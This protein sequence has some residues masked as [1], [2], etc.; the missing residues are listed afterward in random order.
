MITNAAIRRR[1]KHKTRIKFLKIKNLTIEPQALTKGAYW[2]E[3]GSEPVRIGDVTHIFFPAAD[4]R[5]GVRRV[6]VI[7][8]A[9]ESGRR[10]LVQCA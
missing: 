9:D 7:L 5:V 3:D 2:F 6:K 1:E 10:W 4:W 8:L